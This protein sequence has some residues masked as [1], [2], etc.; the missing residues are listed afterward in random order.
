MPEN[1]RAAFLF[2]RRA[3]LKMPVA[4]AA[5]ST[6]N[7]L[8]KSQP[9]QAAAPASSVPLSK[10]ERV[11]LVTTSW[12]TFESGYHNGPMVHFE[13]LDPEEYMEGVKRA[14][15][16]VV[17]I[18]TKSHWGYAYY[19]T[20]V[21]TRHPNLKYDLIEKLV[22]AGHRRGMAV[23]AY[24]SGQV[25]L[26]SALKHPEWISRN[27]DGSLANVGQ[28]IW[29]CHHAP[30]GD[31][32]RGMYQE[33]FSQ[34]DFDGLFIDGAPYPRWVSEPVCHCQ[35]CQKKYR[36]DK[37]ESFLEG[38]D[39]PSGYRKRVDWF[40]EASEKYLDEVAQ[41]VRTVSKQSELPICYNGASPFEMPTK[42]LKKASGMYTEPVDSPTGLSVG[43]IVIRGW[44]LPG[45]QVGFFW[46]GYNLDPLPMD[47]FRTAA[48]LLQAVHPRFI[49]D[50]QNMPDGRQRP[51][52]WEWAGALQADV[53][54][55]EG[56]LKD[57]EPITSLGV[58]FSEPTRDYLQAVRKGSLS[59]LA[60]NFHPSILGSVELCSRTQYP[61]EVLPNWRL[62]PE[63]LADFDLIVLPEVESL[64][65]A[66]GRALRTYVEKGGKL[67]A[68]W[69]CGLVNE[70]GEPRANF[71]LNDVFG[72]DWVE[73]VTTYAGKDGPGIYFQSNGHTLSA[74]LGKGEVA[75]LGKGGGSPPSFCPF[76]RVK[77]TAESI[78]DYR[79]PYPVPDI[80]KHIFQTW[81]VAPPGNERI[82]PAATLNRF[83]QGQ[84]LLVGVPLFQHYNPDLHWIELWIN[85]LLKR[86]VP[87]PPIRAE[88]SRAI[89]AA[90]Y[91]Q[92]PKQLLVQMVNNTMW[93]SR[94][95]GA[96]LRDIDL[97]GRSDRFAVRSARQLWPKEQ[98]LAI[99]AGPQWR[100]RVPE[101]ALHT[102]IAV[103][104]A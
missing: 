102:I 55:V 82:A 18:Q 40:K 39:T 7:S 96:P 41:I 86:L 24:Y 104:L 81:N 80:E 76:L 1:T 83:G 16:E 79:L 77:G 78:L 3:F 100:I 28:F 9:P 15:T 75:I 103:Q 22:D 37:G 88:G 54:K 23:V 73:E 44:R 38:L 69:K 42:I 98:T 89:H 92:G 66:E 97:V 95:L 91:R 36:E 25:D 34:Y 68:T 72:V 63:V 30:Y 8:A 50:H 27:P 46:P 43:A 51:E 32:A 45:P 94:G 17:V 93:T 57:L 99:T 74:F 13:A 84:A 29:C 52:F 70:R 56:L 10:Q 35:W 14:N 49:T 19:N 31:Y 65:D 20:K 4:A 26:Q 85:G 6:V 2:D 47:Q 21:G 59:F 60:G 5:V 48:G 64:S 33:I 11:K 87:N 101:V 53:K 58:V 90:F 71:L 67:L 62:T 12:R 61:V